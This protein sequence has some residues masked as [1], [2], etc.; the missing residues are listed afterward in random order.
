MNGLVSLLAAL[1]LPGLVGAD[2]VRVRGPARLARGG[3]WYFEHPH[4]HW[5]RGLVDPSTWRSAHAPRGRR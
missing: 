5:R 4:T 2:V 1:A 3:P